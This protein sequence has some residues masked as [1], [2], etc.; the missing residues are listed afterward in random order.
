MTERL[1]NISEEFVDLSLKLTN[2]L[3]SAIDESNR[4]IERMDSLGDLSCPNC[5]SVISRDDLFCGECRMKLP[6]L[7]KCP[8]CSANVDLTAKYC[9]KYGI[10]FGEN[11]NNLAKIDQIDSAVDK[12]H[13]EM[14]SLDEIV[15]Q[16]NTIAEKGSS[17]MEEINKAIDR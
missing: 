7:N 9:S 15:I 11:T 6:P 4:A 16:I 3:V 8:E 13:A 2:Q 12:A 17:E 10:E 1:T 14:Q 5:G